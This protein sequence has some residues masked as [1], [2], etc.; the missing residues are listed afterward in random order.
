MIFLKRY[1]Y[2][3]ILIFT[4]TITVQSLSAQ[5]L[6]EK[7]VVSLL[8]CSSGTE[9]YTAFGHTAIRVYDPVK[10]FDLAYNYGVFNFNDPNFYSN[11]IIG[12][13]SYRLQRESMTRFADYYRYFNRSVYEQ[14]LNLPLE[15]RQEVFDFLQENAKPENMSYEYDYFRNN[16]ATKV[17]DV[18]DIILKDDIVYNYTD[19][20]TDNGFRGLMKPYI[21]N[22]M[23]WV[24]LGS[25][26]ILGWKSDLKTHPKQSTFLPEYL[27]DIY[28]NSQIDIN[29]NKE[30]LV[31]EARLILPRKHEQSINIPFYTKP[32]FIT[33]V[34]A[35]IILIITYIGFRKNSYS[36]LLDKTIWSLN[37][38]IG[39]A[40][41][42]TWLFTQHIYSAYNLNLL[43]LSP[44]AIAFLHKRVSKMWIILRYAFI[45]TLII[46][47][48]GWSL[49][50]QEFNSAFFPLII[51]FLIRAIK[52]V[53]MFKA[54]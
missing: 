32:L 35:F 28:S 49:L 3:F 53:K 18:F 46:A 2:I 48:I 43:W 1:R 44:L 24:K 17:V 6:S 19:V 29:G 21:N 5:R 27:R 22:Q 16:C 37:A 9:F 7:S 23:P 4:I 12:K 39:I 25:D 47:T 15:K 41:L 33:S 8:T 30:P 45:V 10:G 40:L 42:F 26:I 14:K 51:I 13:P 36:N 20:N 31:Y 34:I 54:K 50:P 38:I 11:F 52:H